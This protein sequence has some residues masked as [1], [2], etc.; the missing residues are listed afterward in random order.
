MML[1]WPT[2]PFVSSQPVG[3]VVEEIPHYAP[4]FGALDVELHP[5]RS[6]VQFLKDL[7]E[8]SAGD[9]TDTRATPSGHQKENAPQHDIE[10]LEHSGRA[11]LRP[12]RFKQFEASGD[13]RHGE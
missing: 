13:A 3:E 1:G 6:L 4:N 10:L 2:A 8:F 12:L 9:K 11:A 7:L 5:P